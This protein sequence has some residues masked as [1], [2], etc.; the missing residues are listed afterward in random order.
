MCNAIESETVLLSHVIKF[1]RGE[2]YVANKKKG[3]EKVTNEI[4]SHLKGKYRVRDTHKKLHIVSSIAHFFLH[5]VQSPYFLQ[6]NPP[7]CWSNKKMQ[8]H[9][10]CNAYVGTNQMTRMSQMEANI[11]RLGV[12]LKF[13]AHPFKCIL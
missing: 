8:I 2:T 6:P 3:R 5:F 11:A 13:S 7:L 12:L 9:S 4:A 1:G 10:V